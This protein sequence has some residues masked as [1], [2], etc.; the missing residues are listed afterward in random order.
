[1]NKKCFVFIELIIII[2]II[3]MLFSSRLGTRL[4]KRTDYQSGKI[5]SLSWERVTT[6]S[7]EKDGTKYYRATSISG[8]NTE[9]VVDD[10][11]DNHKQGEMLEE[12]VVYYYV[13]INNGNGYNIYSIGSRTWEDLT[14][15]DD[16]E[17]FT[18]IHGNINEITESIYFKKD[19]GTRV[20]HREAP[21]RSHLKK[22]LSN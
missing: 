19:W 15:G 17:Y 13:T 21:N 8:D 14:I 18:V 4:G 20:H 10:L 22:L 2:F 7:I 6:Y 11:R 5:T 9:A 12:T 3:V 16:I 1:M